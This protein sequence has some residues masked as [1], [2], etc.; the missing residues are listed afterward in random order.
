LGAEH[1]RISEENIMR[2][3][4]KN[5]KPLPDQVEKT[6]RGAA[7]MAKNT[8]VRPFKDKRK[9]DRKTLKGESD[10]D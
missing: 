4:K 3:K 2:G 8:V 1:P 10:V 7:A 6:K 9:Y 5:P